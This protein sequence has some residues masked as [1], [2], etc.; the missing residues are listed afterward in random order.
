MNIRS[1]HPEMFCQ[2]KFLQILE[3]SHVNIFAGVSFLTKLQVGKLKLS[4]GATGDVQ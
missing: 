1:S 3:H 2:E 4:E